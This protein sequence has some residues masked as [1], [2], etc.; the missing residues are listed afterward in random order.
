[1][2]FTVISDYMIRDAT[3]AISQSRRFFGPCC[4]I[5]IEM[6]NLFIIN[7]S[8]AAWNVLCTLY[9]FTHSDC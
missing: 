7:Q 4:D 5:S 2:G 6:C 9:M 3:I 1:M 8:G